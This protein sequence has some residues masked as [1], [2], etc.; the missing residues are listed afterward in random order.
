MQR[1]RGGG[2]S[3]CR[4][5]GTGGAQLLLAPLRVV[6]RPGRAGV[7]KAVN[8]PATRPAVLACPALWR[9]VLANEH[10]RGG[11][12][13]AQPSA[14]AAAASSLASAAR[15]RPRSAG[16]AVGVQ[17]R[18]VV[19]VVSVG[20]APAAGTCTRRAASAWATVA[21][22]EFASFCR[23]GRR[24][25]QCAKHAPAPH[26]ARC[27]AC[28]SASARAQQGE[29]TAGATVAQRRRTFVVVDGCVRVLLG[30]D[31]VDDGVV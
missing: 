18:V 11:G 9:P 16:C 13:P 14:L 20:I 15:C 29:A 25:A 19:A 8:R 31:R 26:A 17:G 1:G 22:R 28:A 7:G 24:L 5:A 10:P 23:L 27:T 12:R 21:R 6:A 30:V 3:G 2:S 4:V